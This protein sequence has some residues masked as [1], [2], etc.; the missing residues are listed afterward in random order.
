MEVLPWWAMEPSNNIYDMM[1]FLHRELA[2]RNDKF[3]NFA[4]VCV[5]SNEEVIL[6]S[7]NSFYFS[8]IN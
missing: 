8:L 4:E 5:N 3:F 1:G 2:V 6:P 7:L